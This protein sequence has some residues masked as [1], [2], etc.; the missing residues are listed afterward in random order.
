MPRSALSM[1]LI[2][3]W[4]SAESRSDFRISA[5]ACD[6]FNFARRSK[7]YA[8]LKACNLSGEKPLRSRP[9]ALIPHIFISHSCTFFEHGGP[10]Y[11]VSDTAS[12]YQLTHHV[13][14]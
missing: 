4:T 13:S 11:M 7:R 14:H 2:N 10:L 3:S 12:N 9:I 1:N 5:T 8:R 6:V